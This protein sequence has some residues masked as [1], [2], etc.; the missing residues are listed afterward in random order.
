LKKKAT[1][2]A[3]VLGVIAA[4][5]LPSAP[6][7]A[8]GGELVAA[9]VTGTVQSATPNIDVVSNAQCS[10]NN[11]FDDVAISG[12]FTEAVGGGV[13]AGVVNVTGGK[14]FYDTCETLLRGFGTIKTAGFSGSGVGSVTGSINTGSFVRAGTVAVA[15]FTLNYDVAPA[16]GG[17]SNVLTTAVVGAV[18]TNLA[19]AAAIAGPVVGF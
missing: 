1:L 10:T 8:A 19:G 3:L 9:A 13:F 2:A 11:F 4:V 6:A 15:M 14:V 18:P 17:A 7:S 12:A 5:L 16:G